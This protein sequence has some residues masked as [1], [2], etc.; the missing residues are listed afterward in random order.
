MTKNSKTIL[1]VMTITVI[2]SLV[3]ATSYLSMSIPVFAAQQTVPEGQNGDGD[4]ETNDDL[5]AASNGENDS[6]DPKYANFDHISQVTA[7]SIASNHFSA[8]VSDIQSVDFEGKDGRPVY[9]VDIVKSGQAYEI[10]IDAIDGK[11][12][13]AAQVTMAEIADNT[14]DGAD[15]GDGETNDDLEASDGDGETNDD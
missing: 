9:S 8:Q 11:V 1:T 4:G 6:I 12:L 15:T 7:E 10:T 3:G 5:E 14:S 2:A 13:H